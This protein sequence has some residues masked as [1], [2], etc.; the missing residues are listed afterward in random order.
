VRSASTSS[1]AVSG[2][3]AMFSVATE[4]SGDIPERWPMPVPIQEK[5]PGAE[6]PAT[7]DQAVARPAPERV[8]LPA[9]L[10]PRT[11]HRF[12]AQGYSAR[13]AAAAAAV[14]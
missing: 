1:V 6:R 13:W 4:P 7:G 3:P 14:S 2:V 12:S 8:T 10:T 5:K 11:I 9:V